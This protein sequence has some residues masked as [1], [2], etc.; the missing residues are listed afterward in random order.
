LLVTIKLTSITIPNGVE[1]IELY[2]LNQC[3]KLTNITVPNS[4]EFIDKYAFY[5]NDKLTIYGSSSYVEN[6]RKRTIFAI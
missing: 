3:V 6:T 5:G 1:S 4:V 2:A